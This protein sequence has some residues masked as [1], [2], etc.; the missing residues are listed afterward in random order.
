MELHVPAR[1]A[2]KVRVF[3]LDANKFQGGRKETVRIGG[4]EAGTFDQ[5]EAGKWIEQP[6]TA[7]DT[8]SGKVTI[9][10]TNARVDANAVISIVEWVNCE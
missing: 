5:F 1:A 4:K 3:I 8:R 6:L 9:T 10:A 2:G 7:E